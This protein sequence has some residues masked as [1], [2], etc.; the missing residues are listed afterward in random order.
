MG[1]TVHV[2]FGSRVEVVV[3]VVV[4]A[5]HSVLIPY[6]GF[7]IAHSWAQTYFKSYMIHRVWNSC[8]TSVG[9]PYE[10]LKVG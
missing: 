10:N 4:A 8:D 5:V 1:A 3:M 7:E 6:L 9:G 2:R